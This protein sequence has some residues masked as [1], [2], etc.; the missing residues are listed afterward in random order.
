M[1]S[2]YYGI[3]NE[4]ASY[5]DPDCDLKVFFPAIEGA[6][7]DENGNPIIIN[8]ADSSKCDF[9][10]ISKASTVKDYAKKFLVW[11]SGR[12]CASAYIKAKFPP[13]FVRY[14]IWAN[15]PISRLSI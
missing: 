4:T 11:I 15:S 7:T 2:G 6:K 5:I 9:M 12:D 3:I 10:F 8:I 13:F 1:L 14:S